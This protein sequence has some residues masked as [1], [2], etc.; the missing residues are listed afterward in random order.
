MSLSANETDILQWL[1]ALRHSYGEGA[2][3]RCESLLAPLRGVQFSSVQSIVAAHDTLLFLRAFP[4]SP[5][6]A[7]LADALLA[8]LQP[9][10]IKLVAFEGNAE[11][12][13]DESV[14]GIAGTTVSNTWTFDLAMQLAVRHSKQMTAEFDVDGHYRQMGLVLPSVLPLLED[15]SFVEADTPYLQWIAAASQRDRSALVWL[16]ANFSKIGAPPIVR[17]GLFSGMG[18]NM[19]W[20]LTDSPASRTLARRPVN[21]FFCHAEPLL[22]RRDVSLTCEIAA[23][24]LSLKELSRKDGR[25]ILDM[26]QDAVTVRYRELQ[27]T[28][29]ADSLTVLQADPGRGLQLF[30]WGLVPEWRLPLRG[31]YAGL[32]LKNGVPINY[33]EA[34][35]L[36]EWMEVGFNTFYTYREGETAWIY[37]QWLRLL[38]QVAGTT[39][40]SV[41]PYQIGQENEEAIKSGAF[42]FYRKLGFRPGRSELLAIAERE[43]RKMAKD[44]KHRTSAATLRKLADGHIFFEYGDGPKG[45]WDSFSTRT[46]GLNVQRA[47]ADKFGGDAA[48]MRKATSRWLA[49]L[50]QVD[51]T[52]WNERQRWALGNFALVLSL[53]PQVKRWNAA[54]KQALVAIIKAKAGP[55]ETKFLRLIQHHDELREAFLAVGR[56]T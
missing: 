24:P 27:G 32:S 29:Y 51:P 44:P 18:I 36:F 8:A 9:Q 52:S 4:Q 41:Y 45:R 53:V 14:S 48:K 13:D 55:D 49:K 54:Q 40:V 35:G 47:M 12:L 42:W 23:P 10:A 34:V 37:A 15:D 20:N 50:L 25:A 11:I 3:R 33:F 46:M 26:V 16:L 22:Q 2:A 19:S 56:K 17:T 43:E 21:K 28:T 30:L 7:K 1:A 31:Y 5:K 6:V 38:H 39:C